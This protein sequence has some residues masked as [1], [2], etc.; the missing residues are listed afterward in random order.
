VPM[1]VV[2]HVDELGPLWDEYWTAF[3]QHD[4]VPV[5]ARID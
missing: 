2:T 3:K 4:P 5:A 1:D